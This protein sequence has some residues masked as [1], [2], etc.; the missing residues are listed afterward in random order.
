MS[1]LQGCITATLE[2]SIVCHNINGR[3]FMT[4]LTTQLHEPKAV[5]AD[6]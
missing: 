2:L 5:E 1:W 3:P 4:S 6:C